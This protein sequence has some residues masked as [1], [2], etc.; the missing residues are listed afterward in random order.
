[1]SDL[2]M[3]CHA[4]AFSGVC[5]WACFAVEVAVRTSLHCDLIRAGELLQD[6]LVLYKYIEDNVGRTLRM[7]VCHMDRGKR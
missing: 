1:M 7:I 6:M 2:Y 3:G 4:G 5:H